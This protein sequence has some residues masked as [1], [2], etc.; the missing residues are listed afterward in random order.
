MPCITNYLVVAESYYVFYVI[1]FLCN[2]LIYLENVKDTFWSLA[3]L[4]CRGISRFQW[5][6]MSLSVLGKVSSLRSSKV[7][8]FLFLSF[9]MFKWVSASAQNTT[10]Q[11]NNKFITQF[12]NT[13]SLFCAFYLK[14]NK[15]RCCH[16][17]FLLKYPS[18]KKRFIKQ[19]IWG[20]LEDP[21]QKEG[22]E[23]WL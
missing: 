11:Q 16:R 8:N 7:P 20:R 19:N 1:I 9:Q 2:Y 13:T 4:S 14:R 21:L 6:L 3:S 23:T 18:L 17:L 12:T 10:Y 22:L 5:Y 15:R